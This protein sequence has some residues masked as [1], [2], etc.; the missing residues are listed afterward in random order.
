M[1]TLLKNKKRKNHSNRVKVTLKM[2]VNYSKRV[3]M[4]PKEWIS[5]LGE[6]HRGT[7]RNK[8]AVSQ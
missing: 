3:K 2:S 7:A 4:T 8:R 1:A 6:A 5:L